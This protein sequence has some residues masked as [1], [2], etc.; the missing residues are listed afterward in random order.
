MVPG[1]GPRRSDCFHEW[2]TDP[3]PTRARSGIPLALLTCADDDPT[4]DFGA[5]TGDGA[6]TFHVALCLNVTERRFLDHA[7]QP[8]CTPT[9]VAWMVFASPREAGPR[10]PTDTVNR[11]SLEAALVFIGATVRRQ[12][13]P[14]AVAPGTPCAADADCGGTGHCRT[15]FTTFSPPL[16]VDDVCTP[17][18]DVVVPLRQLP[19]GT[20][21]GSR[22]LRVT[23]A[24]SAIGAAR[25][26][27]TLKLVCRPAAASP[28]VR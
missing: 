13:Q 1:N 19:S 28:V 22:T 21:T 3:V 5:A 26:T 15:R 17:F 4:C 11:G 23:T 10:D 20:V 2:L 25:D 8:L 27:D 16:D 7:G 9:D 6:C 12:C 18:T 24:P 14:P